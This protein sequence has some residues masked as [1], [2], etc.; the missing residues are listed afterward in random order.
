[1]ASGIYTEIKKKVESAEQGTVF[2]TSYFTDIA[3]TTVRKCLGRQVEEKNIR[4]IMDGVYEKPVYGKLQKEYI[5]ANP[6]A[7][8]YAIARSFRWTIA[9]ERAFRERHQAKTESME[10]RGC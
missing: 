1:M 4:R 8:A 6:D 9:P 7:I 3:T 5:P 10:S 2:L